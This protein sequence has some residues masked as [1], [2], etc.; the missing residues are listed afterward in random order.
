ME[1]AQKCSCTLCVK[2]S[3]FQK[4]I[5]LF[6]FEPLSK[7]KHLLNSTIKSIHF[8]K[9]VARISFLVVLFVLICIERNE[10]RANVF[11]K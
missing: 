10:I 7:Q 9:T 6:S 5:F 3:K 4:Q 1:N 11:L 2:V 8:K